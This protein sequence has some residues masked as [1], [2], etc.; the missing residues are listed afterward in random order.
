MKSVIDPLR[1]EVKL[2]KEIVRIYKNKYILDWYGVKATNFQV[3]K[4]Y[5]SVCPIF[6]FS[7]NNSHHKI[8]K[9]HSERWHFTIISKNKCTHLVKLPVKAC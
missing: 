9:N 4:Q 7:K 5:S 1:S 6:E 3:F 2:G 8:I